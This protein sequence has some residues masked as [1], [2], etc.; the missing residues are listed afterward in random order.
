MQTVKRY[1]QFHP[2]GKGSFGL[3]YAGRDQ[4]QVAVAIKEVPEC[5]I[6]DGQ[7]LHEEIRLHS[8]L[9]NKYIVQYKGLIVE[10][11]YYKIVMEQVI[12]FNH[13]CSIVLER[14]FKD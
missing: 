13:T 6:S 9:K 4:N 5:N 2:T 7:V 10:D 8:A 12:F 11:G 14:L 3:V 1:P